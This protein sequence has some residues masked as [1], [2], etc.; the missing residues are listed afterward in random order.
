[1]TRQLASHRAKDPRKSVRKLQYLLQPCHILSLLLYPIHEKW[2][3]ESSS[4]SKAEE[5]DSVF[6]REVQGRIYRC[7]LKL[8]QEFKFCVMNI[9]MNQLKVAHLNGNP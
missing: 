1:M 5:V 8:S 3:T 4:H 7:I 9:F 2:F 6:W